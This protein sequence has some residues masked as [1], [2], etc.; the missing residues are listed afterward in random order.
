MVRKAKRKTKVMNEVAFVNGEP[1]FSYSGADCDVVVSTRVRLARNLANFLFPADDMEDEI[2]R[3]QTL[4]FDSFL[5][6]DNPDDFH[7]VS[8]GKLDAFGMKILS[9]R[10]VLD[11]D[12]PSGIVM[13]NDGRVSC[14]V[15]SV[16]HV[17]I[18]AF[19]P[20]LNCAH[21]LAE[22]RAVDENLQRTLQFAASYE[23]GYLTAALQDAGSGMKIAI[24]A[25][26]PSLSFAG[27]AESIFNQIREKGLSVSSVFGAG[28]DWG[29]S[30]GSYYDIATTSSINGSEFDQMASIES[31]GRYLVET[32]RKFRSKCAENKPTAVHNLILRSFASAKFSVFLTLRETVAVVSAIKWGLDMGIVQGIADS[33]LCALLY[34]VQNGH[35]EFLLKN[36]KF[37]FEEDIRGDMQK[38]I[39]R[40]RALIVQESF[41]N[42]RFVS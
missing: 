29:T 33:E 34:R 24:R 20:G 2:D 8:V 38:K 17:R 22:C 27:E 7:M 40:L 36:G 11:A 26:L 30:L 5:K 1:W 18:A 35:L 37:T 4:I 9:E 12:V 15:N 10:G 28:D 6:L 25:H 31:A 23:F 21:A 41:E 14:R 16:D 32:E 39:E 13:R 42:I 19:E 3:V